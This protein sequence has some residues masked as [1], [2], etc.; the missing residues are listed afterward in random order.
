[1]KQDPRFKSNDWALVLGASSGFGGATSIELAKLGMNVFGVHLDR[2]ATMPTVQHVMPPTRSSATR[3]STRYR[4][5]SQPSR[6]P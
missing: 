6:V 2:L 3:Y 4:S 1:M 5:A